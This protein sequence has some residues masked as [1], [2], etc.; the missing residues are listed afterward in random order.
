MNREDIFKTA[1]KTQECYK[2]LENGTFSKHPEDNDMVKR[3]VDAK[4]QGNY[5]QIIYDCNSPEKTVYK[6]MLVLRKITKLVDKPLIHLTEED[7][8]DLQNKINQNKVFCQN[9]TKPIASSYKKDLVKTFKQFWTFYRAYAKQEKNENIDNIAEF[10]RV[11]REKEINHLVKFLSKDEIETLADNAANLKMRT[12]IK[13]FFETGARTIEILNLKRENCSYDESRD[14]WII[15]LPNMKGI[16]TG[17]MP[18]EIDYAHTDFHAWMNYNNFSDEEYIFE[19]S[20]DYLRTYLAEKSR[21]F[22]GWKVTPK[23]FRKSCAMHLVNLD[24]NEQYIKA[25]MGWSPSSKAI[26]H[27]ISQKAIKRP[28]KLKEAFVASPASEMEEMR[29]RMKQMETLLLQKFA[30]GF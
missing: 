30:E 3:F 17:K 23:L 18:I 8:I 9:T 1:T 10:F 20:Y 11:R 16:S 6:N 15:K 14:K 7:I 24:I 19:Y 22:L 26:S 13:T 21:K 29:V 12:L 25:H 5:R 4:F 2:L 27:Y 28:D